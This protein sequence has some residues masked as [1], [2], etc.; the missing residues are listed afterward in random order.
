MIEQ[1]LLQLL[2]EAPDQL[3]FEQVLEVINDNY[4]FTA[5][6]FDNGEVTNQA[7]ENQGSC[8]VFAFAQQHQLNEQQTL[9]LFAE[10]YRQVKDHPDG[11]DHLNIRAFMKSGWEGV[12]IHGTALTAR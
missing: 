5:C 10:H 4:G 3:V 12:T 6:A 7:T 11:D 1:Q 2:D 8:R 9:A